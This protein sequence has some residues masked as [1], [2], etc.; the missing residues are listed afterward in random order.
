MKRAK[1]TK[2]RTIGP[3][4]SET[5]FFISPIGDENSNQRKRSDNLIEHVIEVALQDFDLTCV[6]A[7]HIAA[8]GMIS[9]QILEKIIT[10]AL[11]IADLTDFNANVYYELAVRHALNLPC[12]LLI[13]EGQLPPF[14]IKDMRVISYNLQDISKLKPVQNA[15]RTTIDHSL[16]AE[17]SDNPI[18]LAFRLNE[19]SHRR[20]ADDKGN[21]LQT[22]ASHLRQMNAVLS[23]VRDVVDFQSESMFGEMN[24]DELLRQ[25][26]MSPIEVASQLD[27]IDSEVIRIRSIARVHLPKELQDTFD[28]RYHSIVRSLKLLKEEFRIND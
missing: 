23:H 13:E 3:E 25:S 18:S 21:Q 19:I 4:A 8:V 7:D 14:D 28:R 2:A 24:I 16:N 12:V 1:S 17:I 11:V 20:S 27:L 5:C 22:I 10:S 26:N 6:R 15:V 9:Q